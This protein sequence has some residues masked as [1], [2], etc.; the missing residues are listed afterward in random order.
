M[1]LKIKLIDRIM[2]RLDKDRNR[3]LAKNAAPFPVEPS[4]WTSDSG[5]AEVEFVIQGEKEVFPIEAK[6]G[7]NTKA[8]SLRVYRELFNPPYA[9]RTSLQPYHD[10]E[11]VK[12]IPLYAFGIHISRLLSPAR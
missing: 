11:N 2:Q 4:Y 8:K 7:I 5:N 6:A 3:R 9:I 12:D 10:G 1:P